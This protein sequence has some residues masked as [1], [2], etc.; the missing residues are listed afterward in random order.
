LTQ[1]EELNVAQSMFVMDSLWNLDQNQLNIPSKMKTVNDIRV[2]K[3]S[4]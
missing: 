4:S 2:I 3:T 1:I